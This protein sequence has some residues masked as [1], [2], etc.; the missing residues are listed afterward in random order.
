VPDKEKYPEDKDDTLFRS[1][2]LAVPL[3]EVKANFERYGLLDGK[4]RFLKGWFES[5]LPEA[6]I[7]KLAVM[8]LDG[9]LYGSTMD[10]LVSLYPKLS[11]GGYVIIDDFGAM[12]TCRKAVMDYR[13]SNGIDDEMINID[14]S[15]AYWRRSG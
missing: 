6:P 7:E 2:E 12:P 10:A 1:K 5:T 11:V 3:E 14:W 8:R 9:D 4:V 15:G 13:E